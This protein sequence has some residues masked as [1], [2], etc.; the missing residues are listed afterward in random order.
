M[1]NIF[2]FFIIF[3]Y[4]S[5]CFKSFSMEEIKLSTSE[6][7]PYIGEELHEK[8][9]IAN[10]VQRAL[11]LEGYK[12][13]LVFMP[14]ARAV[15][16]AQTGKEGLDGYLPEY[17]DKSK[18]EYFEFSDPFLDSEV[19][20]L[21]NEKNKTKFNINIDKNNLSKS[22]EKLVNFRFGVVRGYINE[23]YFD[24]ITFLKKIESTSDEK[25][26]I[27]LDQGKVDIVVIDKN[28]ANYY[29]RNSPDLLLSK[30]QL[31]FLNPPIKSHKL[32]IAWSKLASNF[33]AKNRIFNSG[34]KKLLD[35]GEYYKIIKFYQNIQ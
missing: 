7:S 4:I 1:L 26:L 25:N 18:E 19:G 31:I 27:L 21:I 13:N 15:N 3:I 30:N 8:G 17:Y 11:E 16:E 33:K 10:I 2:K 20:F 23:E 9:L 32:F 34:L 14:W 22:Y 28:V 35:S 12:L 5:T 6:W 24:K 29:K